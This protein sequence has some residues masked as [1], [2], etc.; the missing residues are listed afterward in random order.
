MI[1][2]PNSSRQKL[3]K[4][5]K[6]GFISDFSSRPWRN[7]P[8]TWAIHMATR[9]PAHNTPIH[10]DFLYVLHAGKVTG[11][12]FLSAIHV[13]PDRTGISGLQPEIGKEYEKCRCWPPPE[14]KNT[15]AEKGK[16]PEDPIF[17]ILSNFPILRFFQF[18]ERGRN[19]CSGQRE[20]SQSNVH[21][22]D[23]QYR[24]KLAQC[25]IA[26]EAAVVTLTTIGIPP[27]IHRSQKPPPRPEK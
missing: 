22:V 10:M 21:S 6:Q 11:F 17:S 20:R 8:P 9:R 27:T 25:G 14:N 19:P 23:R 5:P 2:N 1:L 26:G 3:L 24:T 4:V 16:W 18:F 7:L 12:R 15:I 13:K